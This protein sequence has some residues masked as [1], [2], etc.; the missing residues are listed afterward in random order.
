MAAATILIAG[1]AFAAEKADSAASSVEADTETSTNSGTEKNAEQLAIVMAV[2][3]DKDFGAYLGGECLTCHTP[4]VGDG[5]IPP[6][7]AKGKDYIAS[8]LLEYKNKQ[9]TSEVMQG[10]T[11]ALSNEE[12]AALATFFSEQ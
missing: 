11:A 9:R 10:V 1:V 3:A 6:I 4:D 7:H 2:E 5:S 8:A 12:I